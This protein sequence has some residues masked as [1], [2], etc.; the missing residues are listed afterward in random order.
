METLL[1]A[2]PP[3]AIVAGVALFISV[4]LARSQ[5][6]ERRLER[7]HMILSS[8]STKAAVDD[9]HLLGTYHWRN[10][11]F[12]KGKVRDDV[13]R[14]YF[15]MLW[16]FSDIQK[17]RTSLLATNKNKRD[18]AVEHLDRGIMTVVLEYVCTFNVIK[19]KL[20]ESDPDEKLFEG[21]YG[22]H[23]SDLCA[24]L[25]EEVKDDTT[26]R[27]LLKVHVNDTEQCLCSCHSVSPKKTSRLTTAA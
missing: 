12:K 25:A 16:L 4:R 23:F 2:L 20:L 24:A 22:D 9:R 7:A 17:E 10:R 5:R 21:C 14:A 27:M 19:K 15:S 11:S 8:L 6:R 18:E 1:T 13:M 26:K 3:A